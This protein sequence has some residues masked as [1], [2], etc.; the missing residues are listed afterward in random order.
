MRKI[1]LLLSMLMLSGYFRAQDFQIPK[2][3]QSKYDMISSKTGVATKYMYVKLPLLRAKDIIVVTAR[4][5]IIKITQGNEIAYYYRL[6][7]A[8]IAT[9]VEYSDLLEAVKALNALKEAVAKDLA[10]KPDYLENE[11]VTSDGFAI[12]YYIAK[13]KV[14]WYISFNKFYKTSFFKEGMEGSNAYDKS[15]EFKDGATEIE[16]S[17]QQAISK[18]E[19]L[20]AK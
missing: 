11:F 5:H 1:I 16:S 14:T 18:I 2:Y 12:G 9:Y 20:K 3:R 15:L 10:N 7:A 4:P 13:E 6:E 19:E 8:H 17:F